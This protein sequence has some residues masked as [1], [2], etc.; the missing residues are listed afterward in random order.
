MKV[1]AFHPPVATQAAAHAAPKAAAHAAPKGPQL[2]IG[3]KTDHVAFSGSK[4]R[5]N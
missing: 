2:N 5:H 4:K 1:A 3:P